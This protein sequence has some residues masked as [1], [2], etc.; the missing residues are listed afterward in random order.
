MTDLQISIVHDDNPA[1]A[2][3]SA[4]L[5]S[6]LEHDFENRPLLEE[7]KPTVRRVAGFQKLPLPAALGALSPVFLVLPAAGRG[8]TAGERRRIEKFLKS[9]A[10]GDDRIIPVPSERSHKGRPPAPLDTIVAADFVDPANAAAVEVFATGVLNKLC[11][12]IKDH[13]DQGHA[14]Q[15]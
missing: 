5:R 11:L 6:A 1:D 3:W 9:S 7:D 15:C 14:K 13:K 8:F 4:R 12:R 2:D 10:P